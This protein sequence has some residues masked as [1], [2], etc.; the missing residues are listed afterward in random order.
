MRVHF[1]GGMTELNISYDFPVVIVPKVLD[2]FE[3]SS[4]I[5]FGIAKAL[6]I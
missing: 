6:C 1:D 4:V 2:W 3:C 5:I